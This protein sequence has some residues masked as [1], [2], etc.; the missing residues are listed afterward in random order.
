ME[1]NQTEGERRVPE[2]RRP[3]PFGKEMRKEH[4]LFDKKYINLNQGTTFILDQ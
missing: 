3:T 4:F 1:N 2:A